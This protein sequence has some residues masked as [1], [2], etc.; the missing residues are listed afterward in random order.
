MTSP[1]AKLGLGRAALP[2]SPCWICWVT[3]LTMGPHQEQTRVVGSPLIDKKGHHVGAPKNTHGRT[4][5]GGLSAQV[6]AKTCVRALDLFAAPG[7][8]AKARG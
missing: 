8:S 1:E 3:V 4:F 7:A 6:S 5:F 2:E